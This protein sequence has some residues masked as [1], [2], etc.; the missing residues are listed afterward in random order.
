MCQKIDMQ[1]PGEHLGDPNFVDIASLGSYP[2]RPWWISTNLVPLSILVVAFFVMSPPSSKKM[3]DSFDLNRISL[4]VVQ[5]DLPPVG[6][7]QQSGGT[8]ES[9]PHLYEITLVIR[10]LRLR[11]GYG[12]GCSHQNPYQTIGYIREHSTRFHAGTIVVLSFYEG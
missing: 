12:A 1:C 5:D 10:I 4:P 3:D 8:T 11:V 6:I 9:P 2:Y 7:G